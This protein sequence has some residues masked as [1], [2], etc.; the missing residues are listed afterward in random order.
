M[1]IRI[2]I[3]CL[4]CAQASAQDSSDSGLFSTISLKQDQLFSSNTLID[5]IAENHRILLLGE[6]D[7]GDGSSF[8]IKTALIEYLHQQH[9]FS[10]L[11][12]EAGFIDCNLLSEKVIAGDSYSDVFSDHIY[13]IWSKVSEIKNLLDYLDN[14]AE[15]NNPLQLVGIDPQF[16][17]DSYEKPFLT[18]IKSLLNESEIN[19]DNFSKLEHELSLISEWMVYPEQEAHKIS[20]NEILNIID[21]Y[22]A[23]LT[24]LHAESANSLWPQIFNNIRTLVKIKWQK[25]LGAFESR[26]EQMFNNL[27]Y[28]LNKYPHE[29][30]ILWAANAHIIRK[31]IDLV[32][33]AKEKGILGLKKLGDHIHE[34]LSDQVYSIGF[35]AVK[36]HTL[37]Y[38]NKKKNKISKRPKSSLERQFQDKGIILADLKLLENKLNLSEYE[39]QLF[40]TNTN[41]KSKW[42]KHFDGIIIIDEMR[43]STPQW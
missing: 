29:K 26:D 39:S 14:T 33:Q 19:S 1:S 12:F 30:V 27:K 38:L 7:H 25:R 5:S 28:W 15:T 22:E 32:A 18:K 43:P 13:Y 41:Y 4:L 40:Y 8:E 16:S 11:V 36:G 3:V 31:D 20:E 34:E 21:H 10:T 42:S 17:G 9:G 24:N 37:N 23:V 2:I 6:M 35:T